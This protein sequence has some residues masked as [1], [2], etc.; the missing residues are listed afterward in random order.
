MNST[1]AGRS[2]MD[3]SSSVIPSTPEGDFSVESWRELRDTLLVAEPT[4]RGIAARLKLRL[5]SSARWPEL[6]LQRHVGLTTAELRLALDPGSTG[7]P[8][9]EPKWVINLVRYPRFA[10]IPVGVSSAETIKVLSMDELRSEE[11]LMRQVQGVIGR[12]A[13][14]GARG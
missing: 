8:Y 14:K 1:E 12:L 10:W 7:N 11:L 3:S 9:S 6:R 13:P 4:F 5:L 2:L